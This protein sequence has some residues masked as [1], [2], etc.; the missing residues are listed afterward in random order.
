MTVKNQ[1][2][3]LKL[4]QEFLMAVRKGEPVSVLKDYVDRGV[5]IGCSDGS[6]RTGL[7]C[8]AIRGLY[9]QGKYFLDGGVSPDVRDNDDNTPMHDVA[10]GGSLR[11][12]LMLRKRGARTDAVNKHLEIPFVVAVKNKNYNI[13]RAIGSDSKTTNEG[14]LRKAIEIEFGTIK[15][16]TQAVGVLISLQRTKA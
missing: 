12:A 13:A 9:E 11:F 16:K 2:R 15:E 4:E 6:G 3:N 5:P 7:H 10:A 8:S 14:L 1:K